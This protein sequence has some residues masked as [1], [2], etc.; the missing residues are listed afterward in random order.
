MNRITCEH[1]HYAG[2]EPCPDCLDTKIFEMIN[3]RKKVTMS[4]EQT[5]DAVAPVA[6]VINDKPKQKRNISDEVRK[7]RADRMRAWHA[8]KKLNKTA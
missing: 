6:P 8:A 2:N 7:A 5:I 1:H 4:D 3:K